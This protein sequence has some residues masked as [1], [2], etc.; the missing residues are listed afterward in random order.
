MQKWGVC[1]VNAPPHLLPR[2]RIDGVNS[3]WALRQEA[4]WPKRLHPVAPFRG[5]AG[6]FGQ[7]GGHS[8]IEGGR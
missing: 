4:R 2:H 7:G 3:M 5:A 8:F 6:F 1:L